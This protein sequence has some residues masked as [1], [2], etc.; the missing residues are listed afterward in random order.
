MSVRKWI[1][2][3]VP[4]LI[5]N[6]A[7]SHHSHAS[8]DRDDVRRMSGVVTRYLWRSPHVYIQANVLRENG[9]VVEYTMEMNNPMSMARAGWSKDTWAAG[10]RITWEGAHDRDKDRAYMG[11]TWAEREDGSR[12]EV[13]HA[14]GAQGN[15]SHV[16]L[17]LSDRK[18]IFLLAPDFFRSLEQSVHNCRA[19]RNPAYPA[20][21]TVGSPVTLPRF[22]RR[23]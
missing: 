5:G 10:D 20:A 18:W 15:G 3:L 8:L 6:S 22:K 2:A 16:S 7:Y 4:I 23:R 1:V 21:A 17:S 19:R 12:Q 9:T 13:Q 11:L 14:H